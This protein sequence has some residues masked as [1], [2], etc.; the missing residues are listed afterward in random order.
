MG[1]TPSPEDLA[2]LLDDAGGLKLIRVR[3][4]GHK[5]QAVFTFDWQDSELQFTAAITE[6]LSAEV[7]ENAKARAASEERNPGRLSHILQKKA[8]WTEHELRREGLPLYLS[9]TWLLDTYR[10]LGSA[11]AIEQAYGYTNQ[12]IS[13]RLIRLGIETRPRNTEQQREEARRLRKEGLTLREI[14][15]RTGLSTPSVSRACKTLEEE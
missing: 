2:R 8:D 14:A 3:Y 6:V 15:K 12:S 5:N 1:L 4:A 11:T 13:R 9:D 7:P 10:R